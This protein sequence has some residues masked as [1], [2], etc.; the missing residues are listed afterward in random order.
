MRIKVTILVEPTPKARP[1]HTVRGG[2]AITYTPKDTMMAEA[3]IESKIQDALLDKGAWF[4]EGMPIRL[5]ATFYRLKPKSALKNV[6]LPVTK[7]DLDNYTKLL[8]DALEKYIYNNDSQITA[9]LIKKRF[10]DPPRIELLLEDDTE[11]PG[12]F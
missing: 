5:E 1:R 12:W 7:P 11:A 4:S 3:R 9:M 10:G 2:R 6:K 8:T